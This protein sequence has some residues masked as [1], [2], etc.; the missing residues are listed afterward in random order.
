MPDLIPRH[1]YTHV[2][3]YTHIYIYIFS[4]YPHVVFVYALVMYL[5]IVC[6]GLPRGSYTVALGRA[7]M[8]CRYMDP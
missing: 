1:A 4:L 3:I 2:Y 7:D 6:L 8:L 5:L